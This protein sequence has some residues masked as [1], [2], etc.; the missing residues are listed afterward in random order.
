M[1][2]AAQSLGERLTAAR[3]AQGLSAQQVGDRMH[4]DA[5]VI[6][7][8]DSG[9]YA[10]IG[11]PVYIKGHLKRYAAMLGVQLPEVLDVFESKS[12]AAA[13][14]PTADTS[15]VRVPAEA[16]SGQRTRWAVF[17]ALAAASLTVAAVVHW[18]LWL[19]RS[20]GPSRGAPSAATA[21]APILHD[22]SPPPSDRDHAADEPRGNAVLAA[23][24]A[25]AATPPAA[26]AASTGDGDAPVGMGR[27]RLRLSFSAN[28]W[29]D[30][31][32]AEG[33]RLFAGNG[34]ANSVRTIAGDAPIRVYL[35]FA[36]G[37]QLQVN[38]R[39]VAIGP[40]FVAGDV[41]RFEAGADGVLRRDARPA[42]AANPRPH[43]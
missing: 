24:T 23:A 41:A 35:G 8:L 39:A 37:V 17:A 20:S 6:E 7:A 31:H 30:V 13:A 3:N 22:A 36:S 16:A 10:R 38:H 33:R 9:D 19:P 11:P 42:T 29:V 40:Q 43:G 18:Q 1:S 27:A 21:P 2:G 4:L 34:R 12:A 28:S 14:A 32:D 15:A 25:P 5:W 26:P